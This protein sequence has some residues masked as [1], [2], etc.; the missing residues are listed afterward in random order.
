MF[1]H[2]LLSL[3]TTVAINSTFGLE[4][5][6]DTPIHPE[7]F[8]LREIY[9]NAEAKIE[10][11]LKLKMM[12][13]ATTP[14]K[15]QS[16]RKADSFST[17]MGNRNA[18]FTHITNHLKTE[19]EMKD[20]Q[21]RAFA[22]QAL[23]ENRDEGTDISEPAVTLMSMICN[24]QEPDCTADYQFRSI[25]GTCNNLQQPY[26]GSFEAPFTR[27]IGVGVYNPI[28][29]IEIVDSDMFR[30][31]CPADDQGK[32]TN[33]RI[34]DGTCDNDLN[35]IDCNFDGGDCCGLDME[36]TC[37]RGPLP[38]SEGCDND[39][40]NIR[41]TC[42]F[43]GQE[44]LSVTAAKTKC[45]DQGGR[46]YEPRN[47]ADY[48][49]VFDVAKVVIQ[50]WTTNWPPTNPIFFWIGVHAM[51][52]E[53]KFFLFSD[54]DN[55]IT[56]VN[57]FEGD[58]KNPGE[59]DNLGNQEDC[60]FAI[61]YALFD[62]DEK[63]G[64]WNDI[65]CNGRAGTG[66]DHHSRFLREYICEK[67]GI[68]NAC[69]AANPEKKGDGVCDDEFNNIE[70]DYDGGDCCISNM[71]TTRCD[72]CHC[73]G[74]GPGRNNADNSM[75]PERTHLPSPRTISNTLNADINVPSKTNTHMVAQFGQFLD[76][77]IALTPEFHCEHSCPDMDY[78]LLKDQEVDEETPQDCLPIH[79]RSS[80]HFY[81]PR[82]ISCMENPRTV[83]YCME[84]D[85][86][87]KFSQSAKVPRQQFNQDTHFIDSS[88]VYGNIDARANLL[89]SVNQNANISD[90]ST[91]KGRA[92]GKLLEGD[93][94]LLP[95]FPSVNEPGGIMASG[96]VRATEMP[97]LASMHT[98]MFREHNRLAG[99]IKT[100]LE[101]NSDSL[102]FNAMSATQQDE[103]IYQHA[104]RMVVAQWQSIVYG[105]YLPV[106][107]GEKNL[108]GLDLPA[109]GSDY[110]KG[111]NPSM[112]HEF[113]TAAYRFGHSMIQGII[114]LYATDNSGFT[115][116]EYALHTQNFQTSYIERN[117]GE[118]L[119][120][121]LMGL[122]NEPAQTFDKHVSDEMTDFLFFYHLVVNVTRGQEV[123]RQ[124]RDFG[125]DIVALNIV[126][127]R[128]HGLPSFCC[129][130]K[131]HQKPDFDCNSGWDKQYQ[132]EDF[133]DEDWEELQTVYAKPSD[134]DL[135]A[136]GLMQ[137]PKNGGLTGKVFNA[138]KAEQFKR[139]KDGDRFF[140]SHKDQAGSFTNA[141]RGM[142][143]QRT[144]AGI[145]CDNTAI[146][147]IPK[148]VFLLQKREDFINCDD[149]PKIDVAILLE[150]E[151]KQ[152][153]STEVDV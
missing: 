13:G 126:R 105:E 31:D 8:N 66:A 72:Y 90:P 81:G 61:G 68:I 79:I 33:H 30:A 17:E 85:Q 59:P 137:K 58:Q 32:I 45:N 98:L 50:S 69:T 12:R 99:L 14:R 84:N 77:D 62:N 111:T 27:E 117:N 5:E 24:G 143:I 41:G 7:G 107:L 70:C 134:I 144:L 97:G 9:L 125:R 110:D 150:F 46:L 75:C 151:I 147:D 6:V 57:W 2:L 135:F 74:G 101:F 124:D 122:V 103:I 112:A 127:G 88:N 145:I 16:R 146:T 83:A 49:A 139:S 42:Y 86:S 141:G 73:F 104:R 34:G 149:A 39:W 120:N 11:E 25:S 121:I 20:D 128:D 131:L 10:N 60:V 82:G 91:T 94:R 93:N 47:S 87:T 138:I 140:F 55:E 21:A 29:D 71:N 22:K 48:D 44:K 106:V 100:H 130:Y 26:W 108:K 113:T 65:E 119:E 118:G 96:D 18:I 114:R 43:F 40:Y 136:G 153:V 4:L 23:V 3:L 53:N 78:G 148:N 116:Q 80:D 152:N 102:T 54:D 89:R 64:K 38:S 142:L 115:G 67:V 52:G 37:I 15:Y 63:F 132:Y 56:Y 19:F 123:V 109:T 92:D 133:S 1:K 129:Y 76:H 35:N 36:S 28:T 51:T 95:T